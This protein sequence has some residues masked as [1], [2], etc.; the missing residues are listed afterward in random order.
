MLTRRQ[1]YEMYQV[2]FDVMLDYV[3]NL[4]AHLADVE[5]LTGHYQQYKIDALSRQVGQFIARVE[6]LKM[7]LSKQESLSYQLTRWV[8]EMQ[9]EL[10]RRERWSG[11]AEP[12]K[13]RRDLHNSG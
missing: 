13:V 1:L 4:L 9:T 2:G 6:R 3:E 10:A 8:Q 11:E 12:Q 7:W 5:R